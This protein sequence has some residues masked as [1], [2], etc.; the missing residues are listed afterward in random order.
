MTRNIRGAQSVIRLL[1]HSSAFT[2]WQNTD[3][4][5]RESMW[6]FGRKDLSSVKRVKPPA[7]IPAFVEGLPKRR[8]QRVPDRIGRY[9][10]PQAV[11]EATEAVMQRFGREN[12][13]CYVWWGGS[14]DSSGNG[15]IITAFCPETKTEYGCVQLDTSDLL[16]LH[17]KLRSLDQLLLVELHTHPPG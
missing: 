7:D 8:A 10:L 14:F 3:W 16:S 13:E 1:I 4:E 11:L 17:C 5:R 15:H 6:G 9:Y 12:R 2:K